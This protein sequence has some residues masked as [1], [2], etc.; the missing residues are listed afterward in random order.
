MLNAAVKQD[1]W[2]SYMLGHDLETNSFVVD[3]PEYQAANDDY[4]ISDVEAE[5]EDFLSFI[6][7]FQ[8]KKKA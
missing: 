5:F 6:V 1:D 2:V 8:S 3:I 4:V 7:D